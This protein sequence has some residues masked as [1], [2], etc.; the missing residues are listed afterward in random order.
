MICKKCDGDFDESMFYTNDSTCK[1]CRKAMVRANRKSNADHYREYEK[2]R[3]NRPDRVKARIEYQKTH[4][5][6][7]ASYKAKAL[8]TE[9]NAI[10]KGASY[11]VNNAVRDGKL[12]KPD[13]CSVC[14]KGGRIHGH[15]DDYAKPLD[16]RW[17]CSQCHSD[18]HKLNGEGENA[19]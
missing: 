2:C 8:W 15:H 1:E 4:R 19:R 18:W 16:V 14:G 13:T 9:R 3:A 11:M 17:L 7:A 12:F 6:R 10:K 5:G